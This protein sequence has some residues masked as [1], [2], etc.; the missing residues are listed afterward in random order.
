MRENETKKPAESI[1]G[2]DECEPEVELVS[3]L[4]RKGC[5]HEMNDPRAQGGHSE[6][7]LKSSIDASRTSDLSAQMKISH[8]NRVKVSPNELAG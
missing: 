8:L 1:E 6:M 7:N 2:P 4:K 5:G 3:L